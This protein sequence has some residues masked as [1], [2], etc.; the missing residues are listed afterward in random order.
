MSPWRKA[1]MH[2][3]IILI[4]ELLFPLDWFGASK[5][6]F[7]LNRKTEYA[8]SKEVYTTEYRRTRSPLMVWEECKKER[9]ISY[10]S[11]TVEIV[12]T[13]YKIKDLLVALASR[14]YGPQFKASIILSKQSIFIS[15]GKSLDKPI[16]TFDYPRNL[17]SVKEYP[18][19][20]TF[21]VSG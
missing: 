15:V 20:N 11:T 19:P 12:T 3:I 17:R 14:K 1:S 10:T 13:L 6:E 7:Y 2:A 5:F 8:S 9:R 16:D 18:I 4:S 21:C